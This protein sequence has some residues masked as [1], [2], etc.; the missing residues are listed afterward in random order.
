MDITDIIIENIEA[1]LEESGE[2][3]STETIENIARWVN[4][5]VDNRELVSPTPPSPLV[6]ELEE[7]KRKHDKE[8]LDI[9]IRED[10]IRKEYEEE[11]RILKKRLRNA[12]DAQD[13]IDYFP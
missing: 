1:A 10:R 9:E 12:Q 8:I 3:L 13:R 6:F 11:I 2:T 4:G 5:T 7:T